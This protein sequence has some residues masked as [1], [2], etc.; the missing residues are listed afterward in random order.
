MAATTAQLEQAA[1]TRDK[2]KTEL[3]HLHEKCDCLEKEHQ[4]TVAKKVEE[5]KSVKV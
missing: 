2:M 4:Q 1:A 5:L 3:Q